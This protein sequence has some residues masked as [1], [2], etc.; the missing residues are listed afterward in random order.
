MVM[1]GARTPTSWS[2]VEGR[3]RR[4]AS[5]RPHMSVNSYGVLSALTIAG[6]GLAR[7]PNMYALPA[8]ATRKLS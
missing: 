5:V 3:K 6:F 2:F 4:A 1:S 8:I 7:L